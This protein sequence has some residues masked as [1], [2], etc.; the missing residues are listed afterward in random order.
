MNDTSILWSFV[1]FKK[2]K[3]DLCGFRSLRLVKKKKSL[4]KSMYSV[5]LLIKKQSQARMT[6]FSW[7]MMYIKASRKF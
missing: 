6:Y 2:D 3:K 4:Q 5:L 1:L 7:P